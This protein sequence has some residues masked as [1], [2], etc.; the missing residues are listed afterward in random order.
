MART[1]SSAALAGRFALALLLLLLA[2]VLSIGPVVGLHR[3]GRLSVRPDSLTR[4]VYYPLGWAG[5]RFPPL[6]NAVEWYLSWWKP[7]EEEIEAPAQ[8]DSPPRRAPP[9][10]TIMV[11]R[12]GDRLSEVPPVWDPG[13]FS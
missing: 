12:K 2:Y 8:D 4:R 3:R 11:P 1:R 9:A 7:A 10:G 6:R 5:S 13:S